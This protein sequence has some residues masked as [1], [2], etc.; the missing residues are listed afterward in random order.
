VPALTT[1]CRRYRL[2]PADGPLD[3]E[4]FRKTPLPFTGQQTL[5]W[6]A[7][8]GTLEWSFNGT[9]VSEGTVPAGSAW[10]RTPIPRNDKGQTGTGF[11]PPCAPFMDAGMC[12]GMK[13]GQSANPHLE[14]VDRVV[15]PADLPE[16]EYVVRRREGRTRALHASR[17][18]GLPRVG[19][20]RRGRCAADGLAMGLR[21][22]EPDM[23]ELLRR[24]R[25]ARV[26]VSV[27]PAH[28]GLQSVR[29]A[30]AL[31]CFRLQSGHVL[32]LSQTL[33]VVLLLGHFF[34]ARFCQR[35][36]SRA[37]DVNLV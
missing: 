10:A 25:P 31:L 8:S 33:R 5:R 37:T 18:P 7:P 19:L 1:I 20:T 22:V 23:A 4:A 3:E 12:Q 36:F 29:L 14:I 11:A 13:D 30:R 32:A 6:R 2:T 16:G 24:F 27:L 26:S 28:E 17:R 21:G 34:T 9:Y 35:R 15:V